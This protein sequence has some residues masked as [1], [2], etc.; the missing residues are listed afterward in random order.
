MVRNAAEVVRRRE[1]AAAGSGTA[2]T[3]AWS[4]ETWTCQ[5]LVEGAKSWNVQKSEGLTGSTTVAE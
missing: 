5:L 2:V 3:G 1:A 4:W